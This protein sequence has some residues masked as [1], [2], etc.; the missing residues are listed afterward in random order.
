MEGLLGLVSL[1][2]GRLPRP[3][4]SPSKR[5]QSGYSHRRITVS[6]ASPP[7]EPEEE[8]HQMLL[9]A[10]SSCVRAQTSDSTLTVACAVQAS[11]NNPTPSKCDKQYQRGE[12]LWWKL[13]R[14]GR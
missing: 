10:C 4:L 1:Y 6:P 2:K 8:V 11:R 13:F 14:A 12:R 5:V 3:A 9:I 7:P